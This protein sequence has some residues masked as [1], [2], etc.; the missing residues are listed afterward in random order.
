VNAVCLP[1]AIHEFPKA[2]K[3][4]FNQ[5]KSSTMKSSP[6]STARFHSLV[7]MTVTLLLSTAT[8]CAAKKPKSSKYKNNN[9]YV[10]PAVKNNNQYVAPAVSNIQPSNSPTKPPSQ[11]FGKTGTLAN[12][13]AA[14]TC[15]ICNAVPDKSY[16]EN[17]IA[18]NGWSCGYLQETV[19]D[20]QMNGINQ[21]ERDL[22]R[23]T[24]LIAEQGGCCSQTMYTNP[25]GIDPHD[26]CSLC[27]GVGLGYV[28]VQKRG[29]LVQTNVVGR[30]TCSGLDMIMGQAIFSPSK[31]ALIKENTS[32]YCCSPNAQQQGRSATNSQL[33]GGIAN[34]RFV[35]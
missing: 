5:T 34:S 7:L 20:V 8:Y 3:T 32:A 28:P 10:A 35:P 21:D 30:H 22:C 25:A 13:Q 1:S 15:P 11:N 33:R 26:P 4:D 19:Q 12:R 24:Q 27:D 23:K 6:F 17:V 2:H 31:C 16:F 29:E 9:Q 18:K 14:V